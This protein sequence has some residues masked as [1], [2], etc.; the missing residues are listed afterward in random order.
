LESP[1]SFNHSEHLVR[2]GVHFRQ[3]SLKS[4]FTYKQNVKVQSCLLVGV[5]MWFNEWR[6]CE[7]WDRIW[8]TRFPF[9]FAL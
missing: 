9:W 5:C 7:C 1:S 3:E 6:M 4:A 8:R 2:R